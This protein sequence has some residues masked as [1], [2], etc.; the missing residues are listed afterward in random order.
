MITNEKLSIYFTWSCHAL[1]GRSPVAVNTFLNENLDTIKEVAAELLKGFNPT[2]LYRGIIVREKINELPPHE[3]FTYLS[4]SEDKDIAASFADPSPNGFGS[5]FHLGDYGYVIEYTPKV[6]E[7][8][9]HYSFFNKFP[10][11]DA[12]LDVG[13]DGTTIPVQKEVI[14][15]Q[16]ETPFKVF[17][18]DSYLPNYT[19]KMKKNF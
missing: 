18:F 13:V 11:L 1:I 9:W 14:L 16:P 4:F 6:E 15:L 10:Y 8:L 2:M 19:R 12:M 17:E 3:N 7:V 5:A